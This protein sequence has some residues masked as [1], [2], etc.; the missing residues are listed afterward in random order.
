MGAESTALALVLLVRGILTINPVELAQRIS[1]LRALPSF[2]T[3]HQAVL[4][5][6]RA[7]SLDQLAPRLRSSIATGLTPTSTDRHAHWTS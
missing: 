3:L 7:M 5:D 2:S 6:L 4:Q 1:Q